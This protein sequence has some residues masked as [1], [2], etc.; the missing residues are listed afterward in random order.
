MWRNVGK[1]AVLETL[2]MQPEAFCEGELTNLNEKVV[3]TQ[4]VEMSYGKWYL[5][6]S[7]Y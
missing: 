3:V 6:Q 4:K 7:S 5:Q 2:D 1:A